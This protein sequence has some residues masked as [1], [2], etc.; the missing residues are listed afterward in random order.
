MTK[1]RTINRQPLQE[2]NAYSSSLMKWISIISV[3]VFLCFLSIW[4][5]KNLFHSSQSS[6]QTE[7][8]SYPERP[9]KDSAEPPRLSAEIETVKLKNAER[10]VVQGVMKAFPNN[11]AALELVGD[12]HNRHG[13]RTEAVTFWQQCLEMNPKRPDVYGSL[14]DAEM[15]KGEFEKAIEEFNKA[16]EIDSNAYGIRDKKGQALVEL[17]R[18]EE[19]IKELE[20]ARLGSPK[21]LTVH[22]LLG[23]AYLKMKHYEKARDA[24]KAGL[25]IDPESENVWYGLARVYAALKEREKAKK[26]QQKFRILQTLKSKEERAKSTGASLYTRDLATLRRAVVQTHLDAERLYQAEGDIG[27]AEDLLKQASELDPRNT[28][29]YERLGALYNRTNRLPEAVRQFE[30]IIEIEPSNIYAY[31]NIGRISIRLKKY[32][33]AEAAYSKAVAV[34]PQQAVGYRE[35][36]RFYLMSNK[37]LPEARQL[38]EKAL[39]LESTAEC[40]FILGWASDL[41]GDRTGALKAIQ[42]AINLEPNN[43]K[44]R[45]S[46]ERIQSAN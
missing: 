41:N 45:Q 30:Q 32:E 28:I 33:A 26:F 18:Y 31:L 36:A 24:Y 46:Y 27:K 29:C 39:N 43:S 16:L 1:H 13:R 2:H 44:F 20:Q 34:A 15:D 7:S 40:F 25:E 6:Q 10:E 37:K 8:S 3:A 5:A 11:E 12:F 9:V 35:L 4:G 17:G 42:E 22:F 19:A 21:S 14:G 38:A 23:Q